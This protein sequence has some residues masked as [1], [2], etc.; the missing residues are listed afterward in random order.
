MRLWIRN[1]DLAWDLPEDLAPHWQQL[2]YTVNP[3]H[4]I[5]LPDEPQ[6]EHAENNMPKPTESWKFAGNEGGI[7]VPMRK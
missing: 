2:F 3:E 6:Q 7:P 1:E 4:Q 5:F